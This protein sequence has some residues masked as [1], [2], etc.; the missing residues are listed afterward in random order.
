MSPR[1]A[2]V[3]SVLFILWLFAREVKRGAKFSKGLW[4]PVVWVTIIGSKP[5]SLWISGQN[6]ASSGDSSM[7]DR[8]VLIVLLFSG[9]TVLAKRQFSWAALISSNRWVFVYFGYAALSILWS[10]APVASAIFWAKDAANIVMVAVV[11]TEENPGEA[12]KTVL[13]RCAFLLIPISVLLTKY[14]PAIGRGYNQ[15]TYQPIILGVTNDKNAL[16]QTLFIC[17]IVICWGFLDLLKTAGR[18]KK[19]LGGFLVLAFMF[20]WLVFRANCATALTCTGIGLGILLVMRTRKVR[21]AFHHLNLGKILLVAGLIALVFIVIDV[22][23]LFVGVMGRDLTFTGRTDIWARCLKVDINPFLGAGY[24]N[25]WWGD[26]ALK[27][28]EGFY[29]PL[30]EAHS[31]YI[32]TYLNCGLIGLFLVG[33]AFTAGAAKIKSQMYQQS[34]YQAARLAFLFGNAIY[35]ITESAFNGLGLIWFVS[36]LVL[37]ESPRQQDVLLESQPERA[38]QDAD[39]PLPLQASL[40]QAAPFA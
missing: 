14:F 3:A 30:S 28:S 25:F 13:L 31:G 40:L 19:D 23:G 11:L 2:L 38:G 22:R 35:N 32:E 1:L 29:Y 16:G 7:L 6:Q 34:S 27:V 37:L 18:A 10:D 9:L 5:L 4:I 26:R 36:L 24:C 17:G 20:L 8:L 15:W 12:V 21:E 33:A 39:S